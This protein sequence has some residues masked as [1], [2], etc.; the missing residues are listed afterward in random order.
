MPLPQLAI[1]AGHVSRIRAVPCPR[2]LLSI[3]IASAKNVSQGFWLCCPT[4]HCLS[5]SEELQQH[6]QQGCM[7]SLC[8][9]DFSQN[10]ETWRNLAAKYEELLSQHLWA[11]SSSAAPYDSHLNLAF[12]I[13]A[14]SGSAQTFRQ[15]LHPCSPLH[16]AVG[17]LQGSAAP[18]GVCTSVSSPSVPAKQITY[19]C[20]LQVT[21][22]F[23]CSG[24]SSICCTCHQH[25]LYAGMQTPDST[26]VDLQRHA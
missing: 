10:A 8:C 18:S 7:K 4:F 1:A 21:G 5:F 24:N 3:V 13:L 26:P 12:E 9:L 15:R 22:S 14:I 23:Q 19:S 20:G 6:T 25:Y 16:F 11:K 2:A 17:P